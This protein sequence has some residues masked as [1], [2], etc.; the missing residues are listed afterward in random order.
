MKKLLNYNYYKYFVMKSVRNVIY[1]LLFLCPEFA[2]GQKTLNV[3]DLYNDASIPRREQIIETVAD[4]GNLDFHI[5]TGGVSFEATAK[6]AADIEA[7]PVALGLTDGRLT[8][9]VGDNTFFPQIPAWQLIPVTAFVES[10]YNVAFSAASDTTG[11]YQAKCLYHPAFLNTLCGLR[12]FQADVLNIPGVL[13]DLPKDN[14]QD[15]ILAE[16]EKSYVPEK[17]EALNKWLY[18]ALCGEKRPFTSFVLTDKDED[19]IFD[20]RGS[21]FSISGHPY[22]YFTKNYVDE[23]TVAGL[24]T[25]VE[26]SYRDLEGNAEIF[27]GEAYTDAVNPRTN[28]AGFK[29]MLKRYEDKAKFNPFPYY[30]IKVDLARLDSLNRLTYD[31]MGIQFSSLDE[32]TK[33]FR[34]NWQRLKRYNPALYSAIEDLSRWAAFFRYVKKTNPDNWTSFVQKVQKQRISD[35]PAV[36][37]PTAYDINYLRIFAN[38]VKDGDID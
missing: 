16:S 33:T 31:D 2:A 25:Q 10:P 8:V 5:Q 21:F 20:A 19:F 22:Y 4:V 37:T 12:I 9:K 1:L 23:E 17:D 29:E 11:A 7:K 24:K 35:A 13:W 32:F 34:G 38:K 30:R 27:L 14:N 3:L 15:Y 6:P 28:M 18:E 26:D 36:L